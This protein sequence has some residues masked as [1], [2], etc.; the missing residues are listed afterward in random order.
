LFASSFVFGGLSR[1]FNG[2]I[3]SVYL[4]NDVTERFAV[5]RPFTSGNG[6]VIGVADV[7]MPFSWTDDVGRQLKYEKIV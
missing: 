7:W 1:E 3:V 2:G 5:L 6:T 4:S